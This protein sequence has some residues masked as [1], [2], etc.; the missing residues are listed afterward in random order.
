MMIDPALQNQGAVSLGYDGTKLPKVLQ[1]SSTHKAIIGGAFP[2]HFI[3]IAGKSEDWIKAKLLPDSDIE[4][5]DE[6]KVAVLSVQNTKKG[7]PCFAVLVGQPQT[8]N[9]ASS[10]N[11]SVAMVVDRVAK[12]TGMFQLA[13]VSAD[14]VGCDNKGMMYTL[15]SFLRGKKRYVG[16]IDPNHN[17]KNH[18]YQILGGS[19]ST[20]I[21]NYIIDGKLL[22][23]AGV[24][25]LLW[26]VKDFASDLLVLKLASLDTVEK[27]CLLGNEDEGSV[28]VLCA[29]LYFMGAQ[30]TSV[31]SKT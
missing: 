17:A 30:L 25:Q 4:R 16:M 8:I 6:I 28:G 10:F 19:S 24:S 12:E 27:L 13:S 26:R 1:V 31:N 11:E 21:G 3:S 23:L 18:R 15:L 2:N 29:A 14:G 9:V 5:A 7:K 22:R 20:W